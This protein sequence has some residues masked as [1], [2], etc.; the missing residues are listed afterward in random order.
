MSRMPLLS[1]V[2]YLAAR[3]AP[4]PVAPYYLQT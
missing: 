3:Y 2:L 1:V 4:V